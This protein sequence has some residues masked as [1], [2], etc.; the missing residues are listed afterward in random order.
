MTQPQTQQSRRSVLA[1]LAT[2]LAAGGAG[3]SALG[4]TESTDGKLSLPSV[5][6]TGDLPS[7]EV[8]LVPDNTVTLLNFFATWCKPCIEEMPVFR[9]LRSEYD[10]ETLHIVSI[11]PEIDEELIT[12]F[13][14]KHDGTWPVVNDPALKAT[15]KW[16]ANSYPTNLLFDQ[17]GTEVTDGGHGIL[18]RNY[19]ELNAKIAPLIENT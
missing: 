3:C 1:T 5:V 18:A 19:E 10:P 11:T 15:D 2:T 9:R 16:N 17:D 13:W 6:T 4:E 12:A 8:V 14:E 7:G